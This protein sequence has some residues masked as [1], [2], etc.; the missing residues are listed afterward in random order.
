MNTRIQRIM[1]EIEKTNDKIR[2]FQSR[3]REL[4]KQKMELENMEIVDVV[5]K[6]DISLTDL[7]AL[8]K[9]SQNIQNASGQ[10]GPKPTTY[11][12]DMEK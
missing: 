5:R 4:E 9:G 10:L 12:E 8:L 11:K 1:K 6:M 7:G 3:L 2:E